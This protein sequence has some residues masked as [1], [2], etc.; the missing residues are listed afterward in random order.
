[1]DI[2]PAAELVASLIVALFPEL[3]VTVT[4][5]VAVETPKLVVALIEFVETPVTNPLASTVIVGI[6]VVEP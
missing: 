5:P 6:A 3:L 1:M 2:T 4:E